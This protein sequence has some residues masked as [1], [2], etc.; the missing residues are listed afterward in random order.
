MIF[1]AFEVSILCFSVSR[2]D[3][4]ILLRRSTW[5]SL[6]P[7]RLFRSW[8]TTTRPAP[9]TS[10]SSMPTRW[11][12]EDNLKQY[13]L[14][15]LTV[16]MIWEKKLIG[17]QAIVPSWDQDQES[18]LIIWINLEIIRN[19]WKNPCDPEFDVVWPSSK[20][21]T[22]TTSWAWPCWG[23]GASLPST[24]FSGEG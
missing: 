17:T 7:P 21:T 12:N 22:A 3:D 18:N 8:L 15:V 11:N 6:Q 10:P 20:T 14:L 19:T 5:R 2:W 1:S 9:L 23:R 4:L 13:C 16:V 24:M